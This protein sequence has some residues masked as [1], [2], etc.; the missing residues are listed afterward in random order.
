MQEEPGAEIQVCFPAAGCK[1]RLFLSMIK[2]EWEQEESFMLFHLRKKKGCK[3]WK[4]EIEGSREGKD[5][6]PDLL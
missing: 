4:D 3:S 1:T 5:T 2:G 6:C